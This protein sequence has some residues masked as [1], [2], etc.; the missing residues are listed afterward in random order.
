MKITKRYPSISIVTVSYNTPIN[1]W[2]KTLDAISS[3]DYPH[4]Q[5]EHIV[6]DG[7]S[8]NGTIEFLKRYHAKVVVRE[9][10]LFKAV[11]RMGLG[12]ALARRDLILFLEPDNIMIGRT[13]LADM[14]KPF[15]DHKDIVGSFSMYNGYEPNMPMF[16]KY[17]ALFGIND[18]IVYYLGKSEKIP[19]FLRTYDKGN[20]LYTDDIYTKVQFTRDNLPTL[21]DNGH[22]VRRN[23]IMKVN[24][25]PSKFLHTDAFALLASMGYRTYGVVH[26]SIIHYTGSDIINFFK[27]RVEYKGRHYDKLKFRRHYLVYNPHSPE[28]RKNLV[29]YIFYS[30]TVIQ[31]LIVSIRG[32]IAVPEF[33]WFLHPIVC[34]LGVFAYGYSEIRST[35]QNFIQR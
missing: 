21:G 30:L 31:P 33:A 2:K 15:M 18:P 5:I 29:L 35:Y 16:T 3:Q 28:D 17:C 12:I 6:M 19:Q 22:M 10:L 11:M 32:F 20:I 8:T 23:L 9:D 14:V 7:G 34:F 26:N 24:K 25:D 4:S 13:W 1:L 27:R